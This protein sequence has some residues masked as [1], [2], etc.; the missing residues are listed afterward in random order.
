M[1]FTA[2]PAGDVTIG[3]APA[4][5]GKALLVE[6]LDATQGFYAFAHVEGQAFE[7]AQGVELG[8]Q[9]FDIQQIFIQ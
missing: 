2:Y 6:L 5:V 3:D 7:M 4:A 9:G 8:L 1:D